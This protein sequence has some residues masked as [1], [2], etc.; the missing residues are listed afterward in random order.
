MNIFAKVILLTLVSKFAIELVVSHLSLRSVLK[1]S[2][3]SVSGWIDGDQFRR[4]QRYVRARTSLATASDVFNFL[5][6]LLFWFTGG[7]RLLAEGIGSLGFGPLLTNVLLLGSV[8]LG[9]ALLN[10]P[11]TAWLTFGIEARF[12]F[13]HSTPQTFLRDRIKGLLLAVA[14]GGPLVA[15]GLTL[16]SWEGRY[17]WLY[18]WAFA[19]A[20]LLLLQVIAPRILRPLFNEFEPLKEGPLREAICAYA[21]TVDFPLAALSVMDASRRTGKSNA[22]LTGFGSNHRLVLEDNL[23]DRHSVPELVA[24]VAHEVGHFRKRHIPLRVL[25][26]ILQLGTFFL[27][28]SFFLNASGLLQ[29]FYVN[30]KSVAL[31][32]V[33]LT[34]LYSPLNFAWSILLNWVARRQEYEADRF[35]AETTGQP[36]AMADALRRLAADNLSQPAPHPLDVILN[37]S[38]PPL[39]DRIRALETLD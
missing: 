5:V 30:R 33:F 12:G 15:V 26:G 3:E 22:F 21:A 19:T 16:L 36:A 8:A 11:F 38:H 35:A 20:M 32:I 2:A 10:I 37:Y 1:T 4:L 17:S 14:I 18:A 24:I 31:S 39:R 27:L 29:A 13:N 25:L 7:F 6:L 23:L 28:V 34:L 9:L